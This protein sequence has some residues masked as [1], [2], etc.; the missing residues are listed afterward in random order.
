MLFARNGKGESPYHT[1]CTAGDNTVIEK[2]LSTSSIA[3][4]IKG[5]QICDDNG[6]MPLLFAIEKGAVDIVES[7]LLWRRNQ[8]RFLRQKANY[9]VLEVSS[10]SLLPSLA[11]DT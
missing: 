10:I 9:D 11:G 8:Q 4:T 7:I 6:R 2:L 1:T 5:L 3:I